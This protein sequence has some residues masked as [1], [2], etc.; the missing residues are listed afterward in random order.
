MIF[1]ARQKPF[2]GTITLVIICLILS[3]Y[4]ILQIF[5]GD[6]NILTLKQK[7]QELNELILQY[8]NNEIDLKDLNN[9]VLALEPENLD[10][11]IL[12]EEMKKRLLFVDD[13]EIILLNLK[14]K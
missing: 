2:I 11:D 3:L 8:E 14:Q 12:D 1:L 5:K 7:Q 13:N 4:F 9:R 6:H 10:V